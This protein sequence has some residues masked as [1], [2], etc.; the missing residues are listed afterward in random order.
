[1]ADK[2]MKPALQTPPG[3]RDPNFPAKSAPRPLPTKAMLPPSFQP[4]KRRSRHC[5]L[6]FCCLILLIMIAILLLMIA[7]G[8]FYLWFDPK[9]PVFHL[10]SLKLSAFNITK[11]PDGTFLSAK[12]V[13]RI[14]VRNPNEKI[15]YHFGESNVETTAG[16]DEVSLGSTTLPEFTQGQ[17]N[18]TS[19]KIETSVNNELIED[20]IGSKILDQFTTKKLKVNL[21]V[22]TSIGIGAEGVKTGLLGVE[23]LCG[24]VTLKET[25][26]EMP[27]CIIT[28]LKWISVR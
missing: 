14:E 2:P 5:R 28:T 19:L 15:I 4:R 12:M 8:L 13:A 10:Q 23:V 22:K 24:G 26:T 17:Q 18:T 1:M 9:L 7:G 27:R 11:K 3:Y 21:D 25:I 16:D 6:C 20:G